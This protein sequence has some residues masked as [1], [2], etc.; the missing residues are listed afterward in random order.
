MRL[1]NKTKKKFGSEVMKSINQILSNNVQMLIF[2]LS[3]IIAT[4]HSP[5]LHIFL[6]LEKL[7]A[8]GPK[9]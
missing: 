5:G 7:S 6:R 2:R 9:R 3:Y 4:V 1:I 8:R